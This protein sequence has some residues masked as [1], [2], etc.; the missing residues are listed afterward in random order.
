MSRSG[1]RSRPRWAP[2]GLPNYVLVFVAAGVFNT[3]GFPTPSLVTLLQA[4][5]IGLSTWTES[6]SWYCGD[7]FNIC[8]AAVGQQ[9]I[10]TDQG[11]EGFSIDAP[12]GQ[13]GQIV[14]GPSFATATGILIPATRGGTTRWFLRGRTDGR[15]HHR[16]CERTQCGRLHQGRASC[17]SAADAVTRGMDGLPRV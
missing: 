3:S 4:C 16:R 5:G 2:L 1:S 11:M 9:G 6:A 17:S 10:G 12:Q 8:Y 7:D 15:C 13:P 14:L